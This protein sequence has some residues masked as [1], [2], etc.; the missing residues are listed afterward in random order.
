MTG[1]QELTPER[2]EV[3]FDLVALI[4]KGLPLGFNFTTLKM[5]CACRACQ[6][7]GCPTCHSTGF[8][9]TPPPTP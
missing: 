9:L 5:A 1:D 4:N 8:N 3:L 2:E 7:S 6:G